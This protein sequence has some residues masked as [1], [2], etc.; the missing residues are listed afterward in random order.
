MLRLETEFD[1][2]L[3]TF[4]FVIGSGIMALKEITAEW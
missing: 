2:Y 4:V 1:L 3:S